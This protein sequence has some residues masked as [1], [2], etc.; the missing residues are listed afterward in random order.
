MY[1][2]HSPGPAAEMADDSSGLLPRR[3]VCSRTDKRAAHVASSRVESKS[4]C[5]G[6]GFFVGFWIFCFECAGLSASRRVGRGGGGG[7]HM[8]S[9]VSSM[10]VPVP[11]PMPMPV[12]PSPAQGAAQCSLGQLCTTARARGCSSWQ[13]WQCQCHSPRPAGAG[14]PVPTT[15]AAHP[16]YSALSTATPGSNLYQKCAGIHGV[17]LAH[18]RECVFPQH[19]SPSPPTGQADSCQSAA[20][21]AGA[22]RGTMAR[23]SVWWLNF[24]ARQL[25]A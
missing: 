11:M 16:Y 20:S 21:A 1:Q 24:S 13:S 10:P 15:G 9:V 8:D 12:A 17:L 14:R 18:G 25:Q 22:T 19:A 4:N 3:A 23:G 2:V 6:C 7:V 5:V